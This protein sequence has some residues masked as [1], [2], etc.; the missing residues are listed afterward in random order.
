MRAPH[1]I[2]ATILNPLNLWN[3]MVPWIWS[4]SRRNGIGLHALYVVP[5]SY[6]MKI[7]IALLG[8]LLSVSV[9]CFE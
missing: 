6:A 8:F 9:G 1:N 2:Q 5:Q 7:L 4:S 3:K